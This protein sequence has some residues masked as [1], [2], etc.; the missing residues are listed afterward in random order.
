MLSLQE[1]RQLQEAQ[2]QEE[3]TQARKD[4]LKIKFNL[5]SGHAKESNKV[6]LLKKYI[7]RLQTVRKETSVSKK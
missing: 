4:L 1:I 2:W 5:K 6:R 7:A 3:L